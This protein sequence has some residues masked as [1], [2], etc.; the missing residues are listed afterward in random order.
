MLVIRCVVNSLLFIIVYAKLFAPPPT[1]MFW[2]IVQKIWATHKQARN[3]SGG[4]GGNPP[5][6]S[7]SC[8]KFFQVNQAFDV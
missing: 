5:P 3:Q 2:D 6:N 8:T 4:D 7:E 1:K